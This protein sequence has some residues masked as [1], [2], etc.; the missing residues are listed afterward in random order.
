MRGVA[1][2]ILLLETAQQVVD[3]VDS[4]VFQGAVGILPLDVTPDLPR[5][6]KGA[7]HDESRHA[8]QARLATWLTSSPAVM[9]TSSTYRSSVPIFLNGLSCRQSQWSQKYVTQGSFTQGQTHFGVR[10]CGKPALAISPLHKH[11]RP[12]VASSSAHHS[13]AIRQPF[14]PLRRRKDTVEMWWGPNQKEEEEEVS[15]AHRHPS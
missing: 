9:S 5:W 4:L 1:D 11:L 8:R 7:S 6:R 14:L 13:A 10:A 12:S 15:A 3:D 2:R